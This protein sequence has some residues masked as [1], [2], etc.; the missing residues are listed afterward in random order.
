[1]DHQ[2]RAIEHATAPEVL[3]ET[4]L[5]PQ[6]VTFTHETSRRAIRGFFDLRDVDHPVA[7]MDAPDDFVYFSRVQLAIGVFAAVCATAPPGPSVP[8]GIAPYLNSS[9][10]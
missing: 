9:P 1:V 10:S 8:P 5:M 7:G 6:P 3:Y 2:R 4:I